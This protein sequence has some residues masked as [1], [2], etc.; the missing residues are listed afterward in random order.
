MLKSHRRFREA[1]LVL[2]TDSH[3]HVSALRKNRLH[4]QER[5]RRQRA[6]TGFVHGRGNVPAQVRL[7]R[8][9]Q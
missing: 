3:V 4:Q 1:I 8:D 9:P 7:N 5:P 2:C 6:S